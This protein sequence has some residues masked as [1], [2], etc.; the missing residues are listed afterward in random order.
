LI[1]AIVMESR[2]VYMSTEPP[3]VKRYTDELLRRNR[4]L[5][6]VMA[7]W[8]EAT[9]FRDDERFAGFRERIL[10]FIDFRNEL[11]RRAT[12]ISSAAGRAWGDNDANRSLRI[13][14]NADI[15]TFERELDERAGLVADLAGRT[16]MAS[17]YLALLGLCGLALTGLNILAMRTFRADPTGG[18][19]QNDGSDCHRQDRSRH[20]L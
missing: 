10:H 6:T 3:T 1:Y 16:Q 8:K 17:W 19:F 4:E 20:S 13:A 12:Q 18:N 14:L 9:D 7:E 15:E 11:A 2:G 5:S